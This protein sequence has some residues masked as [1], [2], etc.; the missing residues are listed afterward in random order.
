MHASRGPLSTWVLGTVAV[1]LQ[2]GGSV[3]LAHEEW[4]N[5]LSAAHRAADADVDRLANLLRGQLRLGRYEDLTPL[6]QS[7]GRTEPTLALVRVQA[8][9]GF[10]LAEFA[11]PELRGAHSCRADS[12]R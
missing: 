11:R 10:V 4:S 6:V 7:W 2:I 8:P 5:E 9:N 12:L 1:I 3:Y